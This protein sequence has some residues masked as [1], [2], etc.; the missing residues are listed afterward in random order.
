MPS[1]HLL[2]FYCLHVQGLLWIRRSLAFQLDLFESSLLSENGKDPGVAAIDAYESNL[3]PYHGWMLQKV[4]PLSLSAMPK[5]NAFISAFGGSDEPVS[6]AQED[7]IVRKL[8][9]LL[10]TWR[11]IIKR[12]RND[13]ESLNLED[14]RP[15]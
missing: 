6:P 10:K 9:T 8:S 15:A 4:F 11:P 7:E 14:T 5:R 1:T 3:L 12:W 13:F 2:I